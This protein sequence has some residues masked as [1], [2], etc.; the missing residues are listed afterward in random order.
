MQI[1]TIK[2]TWKCRYT[3]E[4]FCSVF[5]MWR[6]TALTQQWVWSR[7][8]ELLYFPLES[9]LRNCTRT[10]NTGK[11]KRQCHKNKQKTSNNASFL[12]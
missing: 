2:K 3:T 11:S 10:L 1:S 12:V 8:D 6:S 4:C 5:D 9:G 7:T